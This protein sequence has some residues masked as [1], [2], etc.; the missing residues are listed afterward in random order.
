MSGIAVLNFGETDIKNTPLRSEVLL[1]DTP[2]T[3]GVYFNFADKQFYYDLT[4]QSGEEL[5]VGAKVTA[6]EDMLRT[7]KGEEYDSVMLMCMN[8]TDDE[9]I[10]ADNFES[11]FAFYVLEA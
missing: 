5:I 11:K 6:D 2:F 8:L 1:Q 10:T 4:T 9:D 7:L 3:L